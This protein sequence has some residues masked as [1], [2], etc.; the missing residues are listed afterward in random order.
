MK[1]GVVEKRFDVGPGAGTEVIHHMHLVAPGKVIFRNMGA[2][3]ARSTGNKN[4]QGRLRLH[5]KVM[6]GMLDCCTI[7]RPQNARPLLFVS[8]YV[9]LQ[10]LNARGDP[11]N[12]R[13]L[14]CPPTLCTPTCRATT[15]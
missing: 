2:D 1:P 8:F 12:L 6:A 4:V 5:V 15:I 11:V 9:F 3:K 13:R 10:L 7:L 14:P